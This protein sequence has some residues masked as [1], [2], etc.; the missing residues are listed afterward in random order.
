MKKPASAPKLMRYFEWMTRGRR[1][2]RTA[3]VLREWDLPAPLPGAEWAADSKFNA[4]EE[5]LNDQQLKA[6]ISAALKSGVEIVGAVEL[7]TKR[8]LS[9]GLP[10][11]TLIVDVDLPTRI[12]NVLASNAIRTVGELRKLGDDALL[13]FQDLGD[14]SVAFIREHLRDR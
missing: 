12:Q 3:Y 7:K 6:A 2:G 8:K 4:A 5:L 13:S 11:E 14:R 9:V 10:D 1:T